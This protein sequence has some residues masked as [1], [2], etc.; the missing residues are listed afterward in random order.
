[1]AKPKQILDAN[2][3]GRPRL[4]TAGTPDYNLDLTNLLIFFSY[5]TRLLTDL[6]LCQTPRSSGVHGRVTRGGLF[7]APSPCITKTDHDIPMN[8]CFL[9]TK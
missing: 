3:Y 1:M 5:L 7:N 9:V 8:L 6:D 4:Y 2:S